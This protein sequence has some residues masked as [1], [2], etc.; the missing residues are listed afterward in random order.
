MSALHGSD[1]R[2]VVLRA[3]SLHRFYRVADQETLALRGVSLTVAAGE[4]VAVVGPSG[5]GKST[6]LA[7]LAGLE[8][9]D[10]G[11]V[12]VAGETI[13]RR[14]EPERAR[15]RARGIGVL[16]QSSNLIEHLTVAQ[17]ITLA[18]R[19]ARR[20]SPPEI[21]VRLDRLG[22]AGRADALPRQLSGGE[23]VRAALAVALANDP[24]VLLADEPTGELDSRTET[25]VLELLAEAAGRG[26]AVVVAGHSEALA[27]AADRQLTLVDGRE[28]A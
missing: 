3:E 12:S 8:E 11:T 19:L 4:T 6:L 15:L 14:P 21:T 24:W 25:A 23:T 28:A 2:S 27:T 1:D 10:G 20:P 22:I 17:N 16:L 5:A 18:A 9:P 26:V 7:C 13:T